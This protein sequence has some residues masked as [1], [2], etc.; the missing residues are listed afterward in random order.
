MIDS[1]EK[2]ALWLDKIEACPIVGLDTEADSLYSYPERLCLLQ[3]ALVD[4]LLLIDPLSGLNLQPLWRRLKKAEIVI[5]AADYDLRLLAVHCGFA[6]HQV[7][8]TMRAAQFLGFRELAL[9]RLVSHFFQ[10]RLEKGAR[11]SNW[12]KRPLTPKM[13]EYALNDVRYLLPLYEVLKDRLREADRLDWLFEACARLGEEA[14]KSA[15]AS[16]GEGWRIKG[17]KGFEPR[18]LACLKTLWNW[19]EREAIAANKPPFFILSHK[20]LLQVVR[21][22]ADGKKWEACLPRWVSGRRRKSMRACLQSAM[23]MPPENWPEQK[24]AHRTPMSES[25]KD[26]AQELKTLRD[27]Q[28]NLLGIDPTLIASKAALN[29]LAKDWESHAPLLMDWQRKIIETWPASLSKSPASPLSQ[30]LPT[31][32]ESLFA[33]RKNTQ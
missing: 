4:D 14:A 22:A 13:R 23:Q 31:G 7:F 21:M 25:E 29:D 26:R 11:K 18:E 6:P 28:A 24:V 30:P 12:G 3:L 2:L 9:Q 16:N 17:S 20:L 33:D 1:K 15:A 10:V 27:V 8:D 5:H 19:R 32:S